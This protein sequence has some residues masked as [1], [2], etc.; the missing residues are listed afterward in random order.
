LITNGNDSL[1]Y[2]KQINSK[3]ELMENTWHVINQYICKDINFPWMEGWN[4][5]TDTKFNKYDINTS[6]KQHCDHIRSM[7]DGNIKGVPI[8]SVI[9]ALNNDYE[10]GELIFFDDQ[11]IDL[12]K[13]DVMVFPSNFMYPHKVSNITNGE[14][15]SFVNWV[16]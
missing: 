16:W 13:G 15:Y 2:Y 3:K 6:M 8:L 4:G 1:A 9:G 10:G 5:F 7:F 14:R 12:K 11:I